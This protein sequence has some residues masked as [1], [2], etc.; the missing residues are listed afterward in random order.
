MFGAF[1]TLISNSGV[2]NFEKLQGKPKTGQ[3][4]LKINCVGSR[5]NKLLQGLQL[6]LMLPRDMGPCGDVSAECLRGRN[7]ISDEFQV[8][9]V[10]GC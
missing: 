2:F 9:K 1:F 6:A 4:T 8:L 10:P 3:E 5:N 7:S